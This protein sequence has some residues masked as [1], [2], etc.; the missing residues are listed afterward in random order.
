MLFSLSGGTVCSLPSI[1]TG[2]LRRSSRIPI[3]CACPLP[4]TARFARWQ[5]WV[6]LP[7]FRG[8]VSAICG[9]AFRGSPVR[10]W[11][12]T[13]RRGCWLTAQ[14]SVPHGARAAFGV[15]TC[16]VSCTMQM[17]PGSKTRSSRS[18]STAVRPLPC[19]S[20]NGISR[21]R[22]CAPFRPYAFFRVKPRSICFHSRCLIRGMR[23]CSSSSGRGLRAASSSAT[24]KQMRRLSLLRAGA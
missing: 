11:A 23:L 20:S 13:G 10:S 19:I 16:V 17:A 3:W 2:R 9:D 18:Q 12:I 6:P 7:L 1:S 22:S 21:G 14:P 24:T 4:W 5:V 8:A 15:L